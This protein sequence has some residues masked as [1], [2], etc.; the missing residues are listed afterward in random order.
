MKI[1]E[2]RE[3]FL[4]YFEE[5]GHLRLPSIPL[6][7]VGDPTLLFTSA[8]MV[9]FKPYFMGQADPPARR[10]TTVQKCFRTTDVD[11]VGDTSHLTFFEM[12][13]NFSVGDY[14][15]KEAAEW[16]WEFLTRD[17]GLA[18]GRLWSTVFHDD[19]EAIAIWR[20]IGQPESRIMRYGDAEGN[21][22]YS[23]ETGPCGPCSEIHYDFG[24]VAGCAECAAGT[25][26]PAVECGR[27][28]EIWNLVFMTYFR[29]PDGSKT[30]LPAKNIDTGAGLERVAW[31]VQGAGSVYET[32][33]FA[34]LIR[35]GEELF[36]RTY[37][38]DEETDRA[39]RVV[40]EHTRA[41]TFLIADGVIPGNEGRGYVLRRL[42][43]R[44]IYFGQTLGRTA[45]FMPEMVETVVGEMGEAYPEIRSQAQAVSKAVELEERRFRETLA[46]GRALLEEQTIP[47]RRAVAGRPPAEWRA[48]V[49]G[50]APMLNDALAEATLAAMEG[51]RAG[52]L[53]GK[54]TF[55]LY[56]TY[57]FPREL[58]AEIARRHGLEVDGD[59]FEAE[60]DVQ[61][62][63]ARSR[64]RFGLKLELS[65]EAYGEL[66][67]VRPRFV[68]YERLECDALVSAIIA[69]GAL[70]E[71]AEAGDAV[72]LVLSE[73][74]FY[75][76]GG[77]Q[78]GD[79]G[80]IVTAT[81]RVR[82][83]DTQR[84][85]DHLIVHRG[86]VSEGSV[87]L[88]QSAHAAVE[89]QRRL[90]SMRNHTGT[91]LL[92]AG[93]RQ[94][95]GGH[96]RQAG[97]L[98]APERLRFDFTHYEATP[99][100]ALREV[101]AVVN[102]K[103]LEDRPI[104]TRVTGYQE[105]MSEGVLAF[106][107]E[108]YGDEVRV[109]EVPDGL[110]SRHFSAELCGGTHCSAT[111]QV[112]L[113][114]VVG[115]TSVGAGVR[116]VE[117]LTGRGAEQYLNGQLDLLYSLSRRLSVPTNEVENRVIALQE[118]LAKERRRIA[119]AQRATGREGLEALVAQADATN[120]ISLVVARVEAPSVDALR[121]MGD[122]LRDRLGTGV[123][124]LGAVVNENPAFVTMATRDTVEGGVHAGNIA[125]EIARIVGGGGG[126][127][128]DMAQAGG[129]DKSRLDEAL[130][131]AREL[132]R[133]MVE[134]MPR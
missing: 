12:L 73:T 72:E 26:H 31:V 113:L 1:A 105:A 71:R 68:G 128:P 32:D 34:A 51:D 114:V 2:L 24:P 124:V 16:A 15:K 86:V 81:G 103:V 21:Y 108:K 93:L 50:F 85:V 57:G 130:A 28:L 61:R 119:E 70:V 80:E 19:E 83:T 121:E 76:E 116:R 99:A 55:I 9:P 52:I 56:D 106:F 102:A 118:E 117:A 22:W 5:R 97:S 17:L 27:F 37:G 54:E 42:L 120:G 35:R 92:H 14:F 90:D 89:R 79:A 94:V 95:L 53:S 122:W 47:L 109:V 41:A 23:G 112:G 11:V 115:E 58:T 78:V 38:A 126:G 65:A 60:M 36:D 110:A 125:K 59:G 66:A 107:N 62:E 100:E 18:P 45:P 49:R 6:V 133:Q 129:K 69:E 63:R 104:S 44:A 98:V 39:L 134:A 96:V 13:G 48:A 132:A 40:A 4:R 101:Q 25:C 29:H 64:A 77:G 10:L 88:N 43:R 67:H 3:A 74:P 87:V 8:G 111:G 20:G 30:P 127:R 123:V 131:R 84:V 91:H 75:P 46:V 7:P 33:V 82:V